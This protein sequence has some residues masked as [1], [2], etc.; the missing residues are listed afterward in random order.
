MQGSVIQVYGDML[1]PSDFFIIV[2][3]T[4]ELP[5]MI[6]A[7]SEIIHACQKLWALSVQL[8]LGQSAVLATSGILYTRLQ[9]W[10]TAQ[11]DG[12]VVRNTTQDNALCRSAALFQICR[13]LNPNWY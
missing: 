10:Q 9:C 11:N 5:D 2:P 8:Q 13:A 7:A 4:R 3:L 12:F 6:R 1:P